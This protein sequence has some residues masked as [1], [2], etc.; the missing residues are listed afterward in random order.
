MGV[1]GADR[2]G[3]GNGAGGGDDTDG[4]DDDDRDGIVDGAGDGGN[5]PRQFVFV[6]NS[7]P[8]LRFLCSV[9]ISSGRRHKESM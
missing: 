8:I 2:G 7:H 6:R 5:G 3:G 4:T 9:F 1:N